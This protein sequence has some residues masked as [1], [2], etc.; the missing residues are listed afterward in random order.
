MGRKTYDSVPKSLRPLG[1][2]IN[3]IVTRDVEGVSKRVAE[4]LKEKRAK[5]AAAAAAATSAGE[6]KEEGPITDAI[7]SSGL[8]AALEDVEEKFKGGLG[9]VFVIG[10]A[11]IYATAL[12]LGGDRPVRIVMTNVEKKG[13]DG[14]KAVFECDT[15]FPIDEELLMEKG[16]RKVSAEEV[17]EWV[18]EPVSGEWK[19]EG[20]V[21]I[22]MVGYERVN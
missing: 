2:R 5:M 20:E 9:S 6:N 8:E 3:V 4:E 14:E 19:D 17:T 15:F 10:G 16:W 18:G 22:Q 7:V 21:R 11:E 1:K 13:V 12:G